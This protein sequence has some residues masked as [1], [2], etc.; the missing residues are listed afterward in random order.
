MS[1]RTAQ[2]GAERGILQGASAT[3]RHCSRR[4]S[5]RLFWGIGVESKVLEQ[6]VECAPLSEGLIVQRKIRD[7]KNE[8]A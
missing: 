7:L 1:S 5:V 6:V 3:S 2:E 4:G 8:G